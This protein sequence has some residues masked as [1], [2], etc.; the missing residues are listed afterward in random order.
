LQ[1]VA[2]I[3]SSNPLFS[4]FLETTFCALVRVVKILCEQEL[5]WLWNCKRKIEIF[6]TRGHKVTLKRIYN[7]FETFFQKI[8]QFLNLSD[9]KIKYLLYFHDK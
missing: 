7:I 5:R 8:F 3:L 2:A 6:G 1:A 4:N 9:G